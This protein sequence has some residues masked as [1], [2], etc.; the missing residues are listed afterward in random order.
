MTDIGAGAGANAPLETYGAVLSEDGARMAFLARGVGVPQLHRGAPG[1]AAPTSPLTS[2]PEGVSDDYGARIVFSADERHVLFRCGDGAFCRIPSTGVGEVERRAGVEGAMYQFGPFVAPGNPDFYFFEARWREA[3]GL[4]V[5]TDR[6]GAAD[7]PR[8]VFRDAAVNGWLQDLSSDGKRALVV[9]MRSHVDWALLLIDLEGHS[10]R[11][12]YPPEGWAAKV[13]TAVFS[14]DGH[15]IFAGTDAGE[16]RATLIAFDAATGAELQ[17]YEERAFPT[18]QIIQVAEAPVGR[19]LALTLSAGDGAHVRVLDKETLAPPAGWRVTPAPGVGSALG[20]VNGGTSIL[21]DW[22]T[23]NARRDLQVVALATG[24][25]QR[26]APSLPR[27]TYGRQVEFWSEQVPSFDGLPVPT[28]VCVPLD[29]AGKRLPVVVR[30]ACGPQASAELQRDELTDLFFG[31]GYA[32]VEP[33]VRGSAG[34]GRSYE[35]LDDG[36]RRVDS[37]EDIA[38]VARWARRQ[39][40]ADPD[41]LV[42]VGASYG[43]YLALTALTRQPELWR[44]GIV[45]YAIADWRT[46]FETTNAGTASVYMREVGNPATDA[47]FLD[48]ISPLRQITRLGAPV[49]MY[50]GQDDA[51]VPV[52]QTEAFVA[53]ASRVSAAS[54]G[55]IVAGEGHGYERPSTKRLLFE[56]IRTFLRDVLDQRGSR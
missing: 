53:A 49:L 33:N 30:L 51:Q 22:S 40:W 36:P 29:R 18:A 32:V 19:G 46:F 11:R 9:D 8:L 47:A 26:A 1:S 28:N 31:E 41:R 14:H 42:V 43:G 45:L 6:F 48:S 5:Y 34:F 24:T 54:T 38:A 4:H 20:F 23:P 7:P 35:L 44:A 2:L 27:W 21:L 16:D 15:R 50:H 52:S 56:S 17:R 37:F 39:D 10:A 3:P 55:L 13:R 12:I 25:S